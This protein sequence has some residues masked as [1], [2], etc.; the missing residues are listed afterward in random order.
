MTNGSEGLDKMSDTKPLTKRILR[1]CRLQFTDVT[2][3]RV[4]GREVSTDLP[5]LTSNISTCGRDW[6]A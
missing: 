3:L 4:L 6:N 2:L 1:T 5:L